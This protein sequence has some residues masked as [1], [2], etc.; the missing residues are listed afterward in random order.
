MTIL[1]LG[2][3]GQVGWELRESLAPLGE[4]TALT[5]AAA[6]LGDADGLRRVVR[7]ARPRLIVNAAAYTAVDKAEAEPDAAFAVNATA[8]GVLADE[9]RRL[10]VPLVHY[11]TDYVFD[12]SKSGAY[13]EDDAPHPR[14]VYGRSKLAG[15]EAVRASGAEHLI[16]RTSWVYGPRGKNFFLTILRLWREGKPLRIVNDQT[17]APTSSHAIAVA[18]AQALSQCRTAQG[19]FVLGSRGGTYNVTAGGS[20]TWYG[21]ARAIVAL[22]DGAGADVAG[23]LTPIS[24]ADYGAPAPRPANSCLDGTRLRESF[25][26]ALPDWQAG[27]EQ[28]FQAWRA[29]SKQ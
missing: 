3:A 14:S 27:L 25:G 2:A 7:S 9:A 10:G 26:I 15:D 1:L 17:G 6:D 18:T 13:R 29:A 4:V 11:S 22:H 20:V 19:E 28:V 12:G 8:P 24:T 21:F 23:R 16:L 5:R